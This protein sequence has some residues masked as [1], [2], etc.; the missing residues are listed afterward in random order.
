LEVTGGIELTLCQSIKIEVLPRWKIV[1]CKAEKGKFIYLAEYYCWF[2][3]LQKKGVSRE[4][5]MGPKLRCRR[6]IGYLQVI[7]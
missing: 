3:V 1:G 6:I 4:L 7:I 2:G 5:E